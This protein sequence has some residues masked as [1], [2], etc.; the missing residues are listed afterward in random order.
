MKG[1]KSMSAHQALSITKS[2]FYGGFVMML[3]EMT[4]VTAV[5]IASSP[6]FYVL[7]GA[8]ILCLL[9]GWLFGLLFVRCPYCGKSLMAGGHRIPRCLPNYCPSCGE[10]LDEND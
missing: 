1:K 3:V 2:L 8:S 10:A 6:L 5:Q 9:G 4:I 7:F